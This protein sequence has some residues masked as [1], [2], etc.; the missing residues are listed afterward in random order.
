ML[1]K[2]SMRI[3]LIVV[4]VCG[5]SQAAY[6]TYFENGS[7]ENFENTQG[8]TTWRPFHEDQIP[9]W[10]TT[11]TDNMIEI[12]LS[13]FLGVEAYEGDYLAELNANQVSTLYQ[14]VTG[15]EAGSSIG[16][17]FAHRGRRGTDTMRLTITDLGS[18]NLFGGADDSTLFTNLYSDG[19]SQWGFYTGE[20]A[21]D[22]IS[23]NSI[24]FA[25]ESVSAAGGSKSVGNFLDAINFG[26]KPVD[27]GGSTA[28]PEPTTILLLG[29]GLIALVAYRRKK[30]AKEL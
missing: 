26:V 9:G 5:L 15:I 4:S 30:V 23:G 1:T 16:F 19:N 10:E 22:N 21:G 12:W 24:R 14:D 20:L 27:P 3:L 6:G 25:Y 13:G 29:S 28:V 2:I 11:A 8:P 18:D 17:E 7:F